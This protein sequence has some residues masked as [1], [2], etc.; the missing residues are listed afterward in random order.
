MPAFFG[1]LS[2]CKDNLL[3]TILLKNMFFSHQLVK[4][5]GLGH[6]AGY[7]SFYFRHHDLIWSRSNHPVCTS[8]SLRL[9]SKMLFCLSVCV[10]VWCGFHRHTGIMRDAGIPLAAPAVFCHLWHYHAGTESPIWRLQ[11]G[12]VELAI[13]T[14]DL[15][16][17]TWLSMTPK[18]M[19]SCVFFP[20]SLILKKG[21]AII[22]KWEDVARPSLIVWFLFGPM[23]INKWSIS[24]SPQ[25]CGTI[26]IWYLFFNKFVWYFVR[27]QV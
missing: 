8:I 20:I 23:S 5:F 10:C 6:K 3:M 2:L 14:V 19:L 15:Y 11:R 1:T 21:I 13:L 16:I 9:F 18:L 12:S 24:Q 22:Y 25:W 7:V 17:A 27:G 26:V 4:S